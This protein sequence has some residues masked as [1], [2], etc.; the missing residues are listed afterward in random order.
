MAETHNFKGANIHAA[1]PRGLEEMIGWLHCFH[2]GVACVSAWKPTSEELDRLNAGESLFISVMSGLRED[3]EPAIMP[4]Y[5]GTEDD[6]A[7][8]VRDTGKD[9]K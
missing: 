7:A 5:V 9:W 6:C 1:P 2:N 8:I 3:G 4:L